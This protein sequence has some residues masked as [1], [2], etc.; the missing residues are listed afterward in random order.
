MVMELLR[1]LGGI[2]VDADVAPVGTDFV[3]KVDAGGKTATFVIVDRKRGPY[4]NEL[5]AL[6]GVRSTAAKVGSPLLVA[7]YVSEATAAHLVRA[8]WS[9][10]DRQGNYDLRAQGLRLRQ[11]LT[12]SPPPRTPGRLP[13]GAGSYAIIRALLRFGPGE[14]EESSATSLAVKT[15]ITQP[16]ASQVLRSLRELGLVKRAG[17]SMWSPVRD[18]LL[19]EFLA[20]YPGPGGTEH[21]YYSLDALTELAGRAAPGFGLRH[22]AVASA[23]VGPDLIVAWRKPSV[24]VLYARSP[25]RPHELGLVDAHGRAD[26]NVIVRLPDDRSVFANPALSASVRSAEIALADPAQMIWD[27]RDLG[28]SDRLEGAGKMRAWLLSH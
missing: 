12:T 22:D 28:G 4:P 3:L 15:G 17:R 27:L 21:Y 14:A 13:G 2:G 20:S 11:R 10:A 8:G 23:D 19:D 9:W 5:P 25:I 6:D 18:R 1:A 24:A 7:P 26:A 16:R